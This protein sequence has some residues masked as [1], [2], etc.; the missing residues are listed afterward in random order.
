VTGKEAVAINNA[1]TGAK[2]TVS[3]SNNA[4]TSGAAGAISATD[5]VDIAGKTGV[6]LGAGAVDTAKTLTVKSSDGAVALNGVV[7]GVTA[8]TLVT[9]EGKTGVTT[10]AAI[11]TKVISVKSTAGAF[12]QTAGV[13]TATDTATASSFTADTG[14]NLAGATNMFN[15]VTLTNGTSGGASVKNG[16]ELKVGASTIAGATLFETTV[17]DL[18][19]GT[20]A[21]DE[22][23][24][25][26]TLGLKT[27]STAADDITAVSTKISSTGALTLTGNNAALA[28]A[29]S[30]NSFG[31]VN[32][33]LTGNLALAE[34]GEFTAGAIKVDGTLGLSATT[35]IGGAGA[36][37]GN[38]GASTGAVTLDAPTISL[39]GA[40]VFGAVTIGAAGN[41]ATVDLVSGANLTVTS[42]KATTSAKF[43]VGA[44]DLTVNAA[45]TPSL[46]LAANGA[47]AGN[48]DI[49]AQNIEAT[50]LT[51][52][53]DGTFGTVSVTGG[54]NK[55]ENLVLDSEAVGVAGAIVVHDDTGSIN[56]SGNAEGSVTVQTYGAATVSANIE[57][58]TKI[59]ADTDSITYTGFNDGNLTLNAEKGITF[60]GQTT[61]GATVLTSNSGAVDFSGTVTEGTANITAKGAVNFTGAVSAT[62]AGANILT[63]GATS[64]AITFD[65]TVTNGNVGLTT[66]TS[67]AITINGTVKEG[68]LTATSAK[69]SLVF[70][71]TVTG[72]NTT[73]TTTEGDISVAGNSLTGAN[74]GTVANLTATATKGGIS[75][76]NFFNDAGTLTLRT[77]TDGKSITDLAGARANVFGAVSFTTVNG[78]I[79]LDNYTDISTSPEVGHRFGGVTAISTGGDIKISEGGTLRIV[80]IN[81][82]GGAA[83]NGLIS[84]K[85]T[86]TNAEVGTAYAS[87]IVGTTGGTTLNAGTAA[88]TLEAK[89]SISIADVTTV[90]TSGDF[91]AWANYSAGSV[92]LGKSG[93]GIG[94]TGNLNAVAGKDVTIYHTGDLKLASKAG[95]GTGDFYVGGVLKAVAATSI[96]EVD[97]TVLSTSASTTYTPT[98]NPASHFEATTI[99]LTKGTN[100]F[101]KLSLK[102][103][104]V[105]IKENGTMNLNNVD[106]ATF[107]ATATDAIIQTQIDGAGIIKAT[108]KS[109]LSAKDITLELATNEQ[110]SIEATA[111]GSVKIADK[112]AIAIGTSTI[113]G[114]LTVTGTDVDVGAANVT[115]NVTLT[116][117]N[118]ND[119]SVNGA[120]IGG[121]LT[122]TATKGTITVKDSTVTGNVTL[123]LKEDAIKAAAITNLTAGAKLTVDSTKGNVTVKDSSVATDLTVNAKNGAATVDNTTVTGAAKVD[124]KGNIAITNDTLK[125]A[126]TATSTATAGTVDIK[127]TTITGNTTAT[128]TGL[129][130]LADITVGGSGTFKGAG[131][132]DT[133]DDSF[134]KVAGATS[135]D[136]TSGSIELVNTTNEFGLLTFKSASTAAGATIKI[137]ESGNMDL[138]SDLSSTVNVTL[139]SSS[140]NI[141]ADASA[142]GSSGSFTKDVSLEALSGDVSILRLWGITGQLTVTTAAGQHVNLSGLNKVALGKTPILVG[143][144]YVTGGE[145]KQ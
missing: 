53:Q 86:S 112:D 4:V 105:S 57:G 144:S 58:I 55:I 9:L 75:L 20:A 26:G 116:Q 130:T 107:T 83:G 18:I 1:L 77:M 11:T 131:I 76:G 52:R 41:T 81:S 7:G 103:T 121:T 111:T 100:T 3:S 79:V 35:K 45:V 44:N 16:Q 93:A 124:A 94:V 143:G 113:G 63:I 54:I 74:S 33:T 104:T 89:E 114:N 125:G 36:I 140:G 42:V 132:D 84:L 85:A 61:N 90:A 21:G 145:P 51:L 119:L 6:T 80:N 29:G 78:D 67:G 31:T 62:T 122:A 68:S 96:T 47:A 5:V 97:G 120:T 65:G 82:T 49:V 117:A 12:N 138:G 135:F 38:I 8:P 101:G 14:I 110:V 13:I 43:S 59:T 24:V 60:S 128:A 72:G 127:A 99:D 87:N 40:N 108:T 129:M 133:A 109:V 136:G 46:T 106:A 95:V 134:V 10:S 27:A 34:A 50:T 23:K 123:T 92:T 19:L 118:S 88:I 48:A 139:K 73:L 70:K 32:A 15:A 64:A 2:I 71:G 39:T 141:L 66:T 142:T 137:T 98:G 22:I 17:G 115:G 69:G 102:G 56:V 25:T 30:T 37:T 91:N 126:L 28:L